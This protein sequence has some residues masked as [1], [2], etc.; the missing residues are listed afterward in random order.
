MFFVKYVTFYQLL[1]DQS[2]NELLKTI[3]GDDGVITV[4]DT[5][6]IRIIFLK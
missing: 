5:A 6:F 2:A 1:S 4:Q 3:A